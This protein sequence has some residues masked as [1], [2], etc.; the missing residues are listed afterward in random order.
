M[1]IAELSPVFATGGAQ[2]Y[3]LQKPATAI[4]PASDAIIDWTR[5]LADFA[6]T[7]ALIDRMDLVISVDIAV[8]HLAGAMGKQVWIMLPFAADWRWMLNRDDSPWYPTIRLFRQRSIGDWGDVVRRVGEALRER[9]TRG[10][11]SKS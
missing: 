2:F 5:E 4:P 6:D 3:S 11:E 9:V 10:G 1:T 7:A 8:A